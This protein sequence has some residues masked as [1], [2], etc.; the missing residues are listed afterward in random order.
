MKQGTPKVGAL[1][2]PEDG[3]GGGRG[4]RDRGDTCIPVLILVDVWQKTSKYCKLIILQ[5]K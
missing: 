4:V 5:L 3:E 2:Q 1:G